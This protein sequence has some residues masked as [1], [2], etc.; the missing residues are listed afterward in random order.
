MTMLYKSKIVN[1]LYFSVFF[2]HFNLT[3]LSVETQPILPL[4][5]A[6]ILLFFKIKITH[7]M[8]LML[9]FILV[10]SC[11]NFID[12]LLG[13]NYMNIIF[14]L[15]YLIGPFLYLIFRNN[16]QYLSK[17]FFNYFLY[18]LLIFSLLLYLNEIQYLQNIFVPGSDRSFAVDR[19]SLFVPEPSYFA[20]FFI[21]LL[22]FNEL[23]FIENKMNKMNYIFNILTIFFI[24]FLSYSGLVYLFA[25]IYLFI[26]TIEK[27][28]WFIILGLLG[29]IISILIIKEVD[30]GRPTYIINALFDFFEDKFSI[31][32]YILYYEPS[33]STRI[34]LNYIAFSNIFDNLF[35]SGIGSFNH[36]LNNLGPYLN[37]LISEHEVLKDFGVNNPQTYLASLVNDIGI[38][39][40]FL[41]IA[42]FNNISI[43]S[44]EYKFFIMLCIS[45]ILIMFFIQGQITNPIPWLLLALIKDKMR[46]QKCEKQY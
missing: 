5:F 16:S 4:L 15:K 26:K 1:L 32:D 10:L 34:L 24:G 27:N 20:F 25:V 9:V 38:L 18:F 13:S 29:I 31:E 7:D 42:I 33:G 3:P 8:R 41:F 35:G 19:H 22:I 45:T 36:T 43:K 12:V 6:G 30:L 2:I 46:Y 11:Y 23:F 40:L 17:S 37:W 21:L 44:K 39:S 28:I 14:Y